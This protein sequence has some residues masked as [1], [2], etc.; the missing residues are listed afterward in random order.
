MRYPVNEQFNLGSRESFVNIKLL[1]SFEA[2][3]KNTKLK[4]A[5][6]NNDSYLV[7]YQSV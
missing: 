6:S 1:K 4:L 5:K 3:S 7:I 2:F